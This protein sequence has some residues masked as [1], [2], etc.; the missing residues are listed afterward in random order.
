MTKRE[1]WNEAP[2]EIHHR[3]WGS[4][5]LEVK[6][7]GEKKVAQYRDKEGG[8]SFGQIAFSWDELAKNL[9]NTLGAHG[10]YVNERK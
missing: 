4:A 6:E 5:R 3:A 10:Y 7:F 9:K 2:G 8:C 1:F